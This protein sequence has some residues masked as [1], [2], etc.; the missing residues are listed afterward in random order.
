MCH[1]PNRAVSAAFFGGATRPW[2]RARCGIVKEATAGSLRR[3][4]CA[5]GSVPG[6]LEIDLK[7]H[8]ENVG[9]SHFLEVART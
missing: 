2:P 1:P 3:K 5:H 7:P 6:G 9:V 8:L 4:R